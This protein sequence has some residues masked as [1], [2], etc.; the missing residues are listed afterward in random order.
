[1]KLY[2]IYEL[3]EAIGAKPATVSQW[4]KRGKLPEPS[5]VLK[6]GPVWTEARVRKW[7]KTRLS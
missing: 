7:I 1:V 4:Y 5:E 6:M 2:G 3:A